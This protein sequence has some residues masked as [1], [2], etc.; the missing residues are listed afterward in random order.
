MKSST[1]ILFLVLGIEA[2]GQNNLHRFSIGGGFHS[3]MFWGLKDFE[4]V[5][6]GNENSVEHDYLS[7]IYRQETYTIDYRN[8]TSSKHLNFNLGIN[9]IEKENWALCQR[10]YF[11]TGRFRDGMTQ[12][13]TDHSEEVHYYTNPNA[14]IDITIGNSTTMTYTTWLTGYGTS[15]SFLRKYYVGKI[16]VGGGLY[17]VYSNA[18]D[19]W[20]ESIDDEFQT[21][22]YR[23]TYFYSSIEGYS[24]SQLGASI[25]AILSWN[26]LSFYTTIGNNF[27]TLKKSENKGHSE[28]RDPLASFHFFPTSHNFDF[29][30]PLT[31]ETG[32]MISFDRI[33]ER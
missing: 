31:F 18:S 9:W 3:M 17:W 6:I 23:P 15:L 27:I 5:Q 33:K 26:F 22:G 2:F 28:W 20:Q 13:L 7:R 8:F 32:V 4:N 25:T 10:V 1:L 16:K 12:T 21:S 19:I 14:E 29:R 30:F 11:F 24:T